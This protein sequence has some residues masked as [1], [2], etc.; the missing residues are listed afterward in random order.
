MET[1]FVGILQY[2]QDIKEFVFKKDDDGSYPH[3]LPQNA[4]FLLGQIIGHNFL[5]GSMPS[6]NFKA[7]LSVIRKNFF[8]VTV[9]DFGTKMS[10]DGVEHTGYSILILKSFKNCF[11]WCMLDVL[12]P[13]PAEHESGLI[14]NYRVVDEQSAIL[15]MIQQSEKMNQVEYKPW[16]SQSVSV[17]ESGIAGNFRINIVCSQST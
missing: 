12:F 7:V 14:F 16:F 9:S 2:I 10:N 17:E 8:I 4:Y 13:D 3:Y 15:F 6:V 11:Q 1:I 5:N